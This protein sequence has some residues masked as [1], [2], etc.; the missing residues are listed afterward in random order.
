ML[1]VHGPKR[2]YKPAA[3]NQSRDLQTGCALC[4]G[5]QPKPLCRLPERLLGSA[6]I[7]KLC[8]TVPLIAAGFTPVETIRL[9]VAAS[10]ARPGA[11]LIAE[12]SSHE[13]RSAYGTLCGLWPAVIGL[14]SPRPSHAGRPRSGPGATT[15]RSSWRPTRNSFFARISTV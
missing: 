1:P 12:K 15:G 6:T 7:C 8:A 2:P 13:H 9:A 3:P 11:A 5:F 14:A 4:G 10:L